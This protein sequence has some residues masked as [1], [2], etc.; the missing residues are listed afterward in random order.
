MALPTTLRPV[1]QY[2]WF[3][4]PQGKRL[5]YGAVR[6]WPLLAH[7]SLEPALSALVGACDGARTL[8]ELVEAHPAAAATSAE[9][10]LERLLAEGILVDKDRKRQPSTA[11]KKRT[12]TLCT[13]DDYRLPGL[14]FDEKGVCGFCQ[15]YSNTD[16][17]KVRHIIMGDC[18]APERVVEEARAVGT[19]RFDI[20]IGYT[21]GKD[22]SFLL[23]YFAK[24]LKARVLAFTWDFPFMSETALKNQRAARMA[25]PNV[26]F[27][28]RWFP[29][30][31]F[32]KTTLQQ[33]DAT[34][35]PCLCHMFGY[36]G[37]YATA[38]AEKIPYIVNGAEDAQAMID[39]YN[40]PS[41]TDLDHPD[42]LARSLFQMRTLRSWAKGLGPEFN[43]LFKDLWEALDHPEG[44]VWPH[45]V[46][47]HSAP[48]YGT[49]EKVAETIGKDLGWSRPPQ[50]KGLLHTS[51]R[52]EC[53]KDHGHVLLGQNSPAYPHHAYQIGAAVFEGLMTREQGFEALKERHFDGHP[54]SV[55]FMRD[56]LEVTPEVVA[57]YSN[58]IPKIFT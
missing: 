33:L 19:S 25:L 17:T 7:I 3:H 11:E 29:L 24:K 48:L 53:F 55:A 15:V 56:V 1:L 6:N 52:V 4:F 2:R 14:E 23:W 47:V 43:S 36:I 18:L 46:R 54:E 20:L 35:T 31:T 10:T 30:D 39:S 8:G 37:G 21:G 9:Y 34:A 58:F 5:Q 45:G 57:R 40:W 27:V 12:C 42:P 38:F 32:R 28:T 41:G 22:S 44:R 51:C 26:E 13:N 49:W 50:Q 16:A